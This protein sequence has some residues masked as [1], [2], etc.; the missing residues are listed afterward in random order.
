MDRQ[1]W[2]KDQTNISPD[3][4]YF[5]LHS[6]LKE[7]VANC[8][9]D[10]SG[11]VFGTDIGMNSDSSTILPDSM[12]IY[13][14]DIAVKKGNNAGPDENIHS[15]HTIYVCRRILCHLYRFQHHS[16]QSP[17]ATETEM[18]LFFTFCLTPTY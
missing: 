3:M 16:S 18:E 2:S 11:Y 8:L 7:Y 4:D 13:Y 1:R 5:T 14:W 10:R 12:D 17:D 6:Y 9:F 15:L